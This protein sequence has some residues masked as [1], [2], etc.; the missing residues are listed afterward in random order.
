MW[1]HRNTSVVLQNRDERLLQIAVYLVNQTLNNLITLANTQSVNDSLS[2]HFLCPD[3]DL[4]VSRFSVCA[5]LPC[6]CTLAQELSCSLT[7]AEFRRKFQQNVGRLFTVRT[8]SRE[9][10]RFCG[11]DSLRRG[12]MWSVC[13]YLTLPNF[14]RIVFCEV[15]YIPFSAVQR[16]RWF[17]WPVT[18]FI[19][20]LC[21]F[22]I[23]FS[24]V[25]LSVT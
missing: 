15:N 25:R 5:V 4:H 12:A 6:L 24:E 9:T 19:S 16:D 3:V 2:V 11:G 1:I 21:F 17:F 13:I 22:C 23:A 7:D 20:G 8:T 14:D 10:E 18:Q